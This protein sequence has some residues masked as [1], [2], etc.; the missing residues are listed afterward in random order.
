LS[1]D[2]PREPA[3][4][5]LERNL[6]RHAERTAIRYFDHQNGTELVRLSYAE[7]HRTA[8]ALAVGLQRIGVRGGDRVALFLPNSP[9]LIAGYYGIWMAG[10]VAVPCNPLCK[11]AELA[12]QVA[13]SGATVLMCHARTASIAGRVAEAAGCRP[14]V[15]TRGA[16]GAALPTSSVR[17]EHLLAESAPPPPNNGGF[18]EPPIIGGRGGGDRGG[19]SPQDLAVLLYTGGTTGPPKGAMLTHANIVANTVQFAT[20]YELEEG[21]E[22]C[23][24]VLPLFHSGGF[25][26][27][28]NVPLYSGATLLLMERFNPL[29]VV[30]LIQEERATR[31]FG[32]PT[33][34]V[35]ILN[36]SDCHA[37]DLS[38][39][40]ACRTNAAPLPASVKQRFDELVGHETLIEGYGLSETSPLTH[41]NPPQR[42]RAGSIGVP[43]PDTDAKLV[44]PSSGADLPLGEEGELLIRGPQVMRGYWN[45][46]DETAAA[47]VDGW[48][49]TGDIA[50]MDAEGYFYIV[51]RKKDMI[52]TAGFK[53]WPREVEEVLYSH[54]CVRMAAVVGVPD[55]YRG[56][57]VKACVVLKNGLEAEV[58]EAELI[59]FCKERLA[60]YKAPRQIEFRPELPLSAAGKVLRRLLREAVSADGR[61]TAP[62]A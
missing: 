31:F 7:L 17:F 24:S 4:W 43:L 9:E 48:L 14:I 26:G 37:Y 16:D 58:S 44:D 19:V 41:A 28:M 8:G 53:V 6:S 60:G 30:R 42:T 54:P 46:P 50:R 25:S 23:I 21:A 13:D 51:D 5:I 39:L 20:W 1:I 12:A 34:F 27:A 3:Y 33:M 40:R 35:A 62:L 2:Y 61:G 18:Q 56:E 15:V 59:A 10:G 52:N 32:V 49:H 11:E 55:D 36:N 29:T 57:A 22:T 45:R 38:S 47:L